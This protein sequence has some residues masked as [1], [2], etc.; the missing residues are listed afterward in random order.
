MNNKLSVWQKIAITITTFM[1][2][3]FTL[4]PSAA[5]AAGATLTSTNANLSETK[6]RNTNTATITLQL[7]GETWTSSFTDEKKLLLV[8]SFIPLSDAGQWEAIKSNL[9]KKI[10]LNKITRTN[11]E[12]TINIPRIPDFKLTGNQTLLITVPPQLLENAVDSLTTTIEIL[13]STKIAVE[14]QT[15]SQEDLF[16]GGKTIKVTAINTEWKENIASN[17]VNREKLLGW[18]DWAKVGIDVNVIN[19]RANVERTDDHTVT[20]TLPSMSAFKLKNTDL[21]FQVADAQKG[22]LTVEPIEVRDTILAT[23]ILES[24]L[25]TA[26]VTGLTKLTEF[27]IAKD[28]N[29]FSVTLTNDQWISN[30]ANKGKTG[31]S[32]VDTNGN[33]FV[34]SKIVRASD[35]EILVSLDAYKAPISAD[36]EV[37]LT[38]PAN[39]LTLSTSPIENVPA[40]SIVKVKTNLSGTATQSFDVVDITKGKK[41]IVVDVVN[42]R[43]HT[44]QPV[45]N[46]KN[47]LSGPTEII[48]NITEKDIKVTSNKVTFTVPAVPGF[49]GGPDISVSIPVG[50]LESVNNVIQVGTVK[51]GQVATSTISPA[52]IM[53]A[54]IVKGRTFTITLDGAEWDPTIA[55][56]KSKQSALIKGFST[57]DQTNEWSKVTTALKASGTFTLLNSTQLR[58]TMPAVSNYAIIRPQDILI[59]VPKTVLKNSKVDIELTRGINI[60]IPSLSGKM[61][62]DQFLAGELTGDMIKNARLI[63][64]KKQVETIYVNTVEVPSGDA[65]KINRIT[66][67]EITTDSLAKKVDITIGGSTKSVTGSNKFLFVY[68]NLPVDSEMSIK[69]FAKVTDT[70]PIQSAIFKKIGKGSKLYNELPKKDISGSYSLYQ[71][72]TDKSLLKDIL[73]YYPVNDLTVES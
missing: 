39:L 67:I 58:V 10:N 24:P 31:M 15:L 62:F 47:M 48:N 72:L 23:T 7:S 64:P 17:T 4:V 73:K 71:L 20:I 54:D 69:A 6:I 40:F 65:S 18:F 56:N 66:T 19:A 60:G 28:G 16:K 59:K 12:I 43:F 11:N 53:E 70:M 27:D 49:A 44:G 32:V 50:L 3:I 37:S 33:Q 42:A 26:K 1:L 46:F 13:S 45:I 14:S 68:Q 22:S 5:L 63:V 61:T 35:K 51:V 41:T 21:T 57:L 30:I 25:A 55:T 8:D 9:K 29:T 34:I 2:L 52:N 38:I 36:T